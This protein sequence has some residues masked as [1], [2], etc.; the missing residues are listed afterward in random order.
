MR[1]ISTFT[2]VGLAL[3][4]LAAPAFAASLSTQ[5]AAIVRAVDSDAAAGIDLLERL[6]NINSGTFNPAGV[7]AVAKLLEAE[8]QSLGFQ[9]RWIA[10]DAIQRAPT[11]IAEMKGSGGKRVLLLGHMDT[12]FEPSSP[13]QKFERTGMSA[14]GPG[15]SDMKGGLVVI[16]SALKALKAAGA[17]K[18]RA[19]TVYLTGDEEAAGSPYSVSRG[20]MVEAGKVS[21]A[22]L[23]FEGGITIDGKEYATVARRGA[24]K[25]EVRAE[26]T[27]GHSGGIFGESLGHGAAYELSR[28]VTRFHDE[29]REPNMTFSVGLMLA[30]SKIKV[31]PNGEASVSGKENIVPG[32]AVALGDLRAL[33][34]EQVA[35][36]E[37]KMQAI[38][39][40]SLPGTKARISFS[41]GYPPMAPT[42][43]NLA[44]LAELN[45][46]NR[47]LGIPE[48]EALDPMR[49]GAGDA[50]F[51]A[52]VTD[53]LDGLGAVGEGAHAVGETVD[54]SRLAPQARRAALLIDRLTR[55]K[56]SKKSGST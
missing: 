47:A 20:Q 37:A 46:V 7:T 23:S 29:L 54:L 40:Q 51:V 8:F 12:V 21:D 10:M 9:T 13:F 27:A 36:V 56:S 4:T 32:E 26:G 17:L 42:P 16:V 18:G 39:A 31:A 3:G 30:G 45:A 52:P 33:S 2:M 49:R 41:E 48:M 55:E 1:I 14:K 38:V 5:Q 19:I 22:A 28:I 44:L 53:V 50:S 25:W 6:V 43:G 11:L 24:L 35:R 15:S 34:L